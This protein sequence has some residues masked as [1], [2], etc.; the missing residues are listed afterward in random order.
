MCCRP[1]RLFE[2]WGAGTQCTNEATL[3][4]HQT[5][6]VLAWGSRLRSSLERESFEVP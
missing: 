4:T 1:L 2:G 6:F 5:G 3:W